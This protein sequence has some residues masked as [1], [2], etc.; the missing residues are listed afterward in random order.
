MVGPTS[1]PSA[2]PCTIRATIAMIGRCDADAVVGR[3]QRQQQD[4]AAHQRETQ[5]HGRPPADAIGIDAEHD[6]A[7][8][9]GDEACTESRKR[10]HQAA[11]LALCREESVAD[12]DRKEAVGDEIVEFEHVADGG[13]ERGTN[14]VDI[15]PL[16]I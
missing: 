11:V 15:F 16:T 12:L 2:K 9:A 14:D 10:Q 6:A 5:Q 1:P 13:G 7:D 4:R 8:R 3:R